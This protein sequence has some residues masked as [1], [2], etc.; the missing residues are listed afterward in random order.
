MKS[1]SPKRLQNVSPERWENFL[2]L[3]RDHVLEP[4]EAFP[5]VRCWTH[6]NLGHLIMEVVKGHPDQLVPST[7]CTAGE[8]IHRLMEMGW[9]KPISLGPVK[10][11]ITEMYFLEMEAKEGEMILDPLEVL[12]GFMPQGVLC[13]FG[14]LSYLELTTQV[15]PFFHVA[16]MDKAPL[17]PQ[18]SEPSSNQAGERR[19]LRNPMGTEL[20]R[21]EGA[22]CYQTRRN[23]MMVPGVQERVFGKRA[24]V[25]ITTLEQTLLDTLIY[26]TQCGGQGVVFEAWE[27]GVELWNPDRMAGYLEQIGRPT[28]DRRVGAMLDVLGVKSVLSEKMENRLEVVRHDSE[29]SSEPI[30]LINGVD[31]PRLNKS[32]NVR[33][34]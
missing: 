25:R 14:V 2:R 12:Q 16:K 17:P 15:P 24:K 30:S 34:P 31:Y 23:T 9:L 3:L 13:Y 22:M 29:A 19:R 27:R 20:F 4:T 7:F 5:T 10:D 11:G 6:S 28:F 21:F 32:W 18:W 8:A 33:I 26:P 1:K